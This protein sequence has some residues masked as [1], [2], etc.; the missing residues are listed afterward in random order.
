[1]E[2]DKD[3]FKFFNDFIFLAHSEVEVTENV[4]VLRQFTIGGFQKAVSP[5]RVPITLSLIDDIILKLQNKN[6]EKI[7]DDMYSV[8]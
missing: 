6:L 7:Q 8:R 5:S 1:M 2:T 3:M 4:N